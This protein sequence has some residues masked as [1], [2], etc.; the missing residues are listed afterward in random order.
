MSI[1]L[2]SP[3]PKTSIRLAREGQ[4]VL[5]NLEEAPGT[6]PTEYSNDADVFLKEP[7]AVP[8]ELTNINDH[9]IDLDSSFPLA[10]QSY[11]CENSMEAFNCVSIIE[12]SIT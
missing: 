11:S 5:L 4:I 6:V 12:A 1:H 9:A 8:L 7:A 3:T 2:A 10:L